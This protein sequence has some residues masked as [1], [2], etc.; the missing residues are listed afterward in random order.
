MVF[1]TLYSEIFLIPSGKMWYSLI[2]ST[3]AYI[4]SH[5]HV[6]IHIMLFFTDR[7]KK[8]KCEINVEKT[9]QPRKIVVT[10]RLVHNQD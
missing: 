7:W 9:G 10:I 2:Y 1:V 6:S 8:K 5:W 3:L 4:Y